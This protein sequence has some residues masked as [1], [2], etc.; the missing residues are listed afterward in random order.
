MCR[1]NR[2]ETFLACLIAGLALLIAPLASAQE[3]RV[4]YLFSDGQMPV[5]LDA[6]RALLDEHPELR[7][8]IDVTFITESTF[9]E[10]DPAAVLES[11]VLVLDMMNQQMLDRFNAENGADL[12]AEVGGD[13]AV[14]VIGV[15]LAPKETYV[16][17][18]AIWDEQAQVYWQNS[19]ISNQLGLLKYALGTVGVDGLDLPTPEISLDF[20]YYYPEPDASGG[21]TFASW[22]EFDAWRESAGKKRPGAARVAIGFYKANFYS[23]D[24]AA[25]DAVIAEIERQGAEAIPV[26]GYPG[27]AAFDLLLTDENDAA[28]A[29]VALGFLF[30][31]ADFDSASVLEDLDIPVVNMVSLYG[32]SEQE[33]RE[34][35]SG[36][37][38]FEGTFQIAV[39]EIAGL[40]APTVVA[41]RER[42]L[43]IETGIA[44]VVNRPIP[45]RVEVAVSRG[46][47]LAE[48]SRKRN[49]DKRIALMFYNYPA[50]KSNIGASYLNVADSLANIL[51]HFRGAGFDVGSEPLDSE[52]VLE[53]LTAGVR[54][55]GSFAPGE[56]EEMLAAGDAV[57]VPVTRYRQ[58]LDGFAPALRDKFISD[59]GEPEDAELMMTGA[60]D[61]R[62]IVV[63]VARYG[64]LALMPQP[65]RGWGENLEQLYHAKDLTPPHQYAAAY[66]WLRDDFEA[67]AVVH[68]GTHGT[69][70]WLDGRDIGQAEDDV[71]DAL[72]G[73]LPDMY[74]YNVDVVGEGLVARRRGLATLIDHMVP[75]FVGG[76]L[77]EDL[78]RLNESISEFDASYHQNPELAAAF[79][80]SI[81]IQAQALGIDKSLGLDLSMP[82]GEIPHDVIHEIQD[83]MVELRSQNIP[84]GLHAFGRVPDDEARASTVTAIVET[85][86]SLL[87]TAAEV[88][89]ADMDARIIRSGAR[90][91][92]NLQDSLEGG[93][94]PV[95]TGGEPIRNPDSYPTG[96]NF[97]GIDP[98]K[99]PKHESWALGVE[100]ADQMLADHLA[101]HGRY[102]Q[103]V[104]F[105]I[106]GDETLRHEGVLESQVLYLLGTRPVWDDRD[107]VVDIEVIPREVLGRPRVDIVIASAAEGMFSNITLL[108]DKAVQE[109]KLIEEA[110]NY[111]RD[112]FLSTRS[113]L[114][115]M[116]YTEE[117]AEQRAGVRIFDEPPGTYNLNVSRIAE[118][119]GSWD[120]DSVLGED[121]MRKMG[122]G[123]GNGFWGEPMEDVFRLALSGTEKVVHSSSTTLYGALDND[124][125]YM[126]MGGLASAVRTLDGESPEL[127]VTNTRDP[128]NPEMSSIDKFIGTEFRSRYV[129]PTWIEGMQSEGYAGAGA[130][131]EFVE[132]MWGW[133]ATVSETVDDTMWQETFAVYVEDKYELGMQEFF[134]EESPFAYQ[135]MTARMIETVRKDYW[136]ADRE[137]LGRL[138]EEYI[139]S[140]N[141]HGVGCSDHTC[142]NP[143]LLRYVVEEAIENGVPAPA[144]EAFV[145]AME[146]AIGD[147]IETLAAELDQFVAANEAQLAERVIPGPEAI[148]EESVDS[149]E[150]QG[151]MMREIARDEPTPEESTEVMQPQTIVDWRFL[152]LVIGLIGVL[153]VWRVSHRRRSV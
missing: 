13:G 60:L 45:S 6:F 92:A 122:H 151:Y 47:K 78:A 34:S 150:L 15:G 31:F 145:E 23:G 17:Q 69:L 10:L 119:S 55:V 44:A 129:N 114:I 116:G 115:E 2:L 39:P 109:V 87:P 70:E 24:R 146:Q 113:A 100:L 58:W 67:D 84:Y 126:Y 38:M 148:P 93:F 66:L 29:D 59:W 106:W 30:R 128:S 21:R 102:P 56:L 121:Y 90:E 111:V 134:D 5:T 124:D 68:I 33:W 110:E 133:D 26:F 104:S 131:R 62:A 7:N 12:I 50:G 96:K 73:D 152:G 105:V 85:D 82:A 42:I 53:R 94:I 63:P 81:R 143:R 27:S 140:V 64:N 99:V 142:G 1:T 139:A 98:D 136:D 127:V 123:F 97:Y 147:S 52:S 37:S 76:G 48:L 43:D 120:S 16:D 83:Y 11:D 46:L 144:V 72:L 132:Y 57:L 36:L 137:T 71:T 41:S 103:K 49:A 80:E 108:M 8:R 125:F 18:G 79:G 40:V 138:L 3:V 86:R 65:V 88:L 95:G 135:D 117:Q 118:A 20:G 25:I 130:M 75:P 112:H 14:V 149:A 61:D 4:A 28:R 9:D 22:Q 74:I 101:E 89:A 54:N 35:Q 91:L 32:R 19:G 141:R 77:Y 107:K 153:A 51:E